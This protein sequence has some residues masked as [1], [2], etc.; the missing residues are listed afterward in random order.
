MPGLGKDDSMRARALA[1]QRGLLGARSPPFP[2]Q[3]TRRPRELL[4]AA[5]LLS[6]SA[7]RWRS[8]PA[9]LG[10]WCPRGSPREGP[11]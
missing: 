3:R 5:C 11:N 4:G 1:T 7:E 9:D 8:R 2:Q 6:V 10:A